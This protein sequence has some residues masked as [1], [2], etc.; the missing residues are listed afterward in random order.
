MSSRVQEVL[1]EVLGLTPTDVTPARLLAIAE[2]SLGATR[3]TL[4]T[5]AIR[6]GPLCERHQ[7]FGELE[8]GR[9]HV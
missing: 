8:I 9:A 6:R 5:D 1:E 4:A 7:L 2:E 3:A